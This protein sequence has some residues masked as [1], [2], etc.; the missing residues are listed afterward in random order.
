[1]E[2]TSTVLYVALI[3]AVG[4]ERVVELVISR[5]NAAWALERGGKEYGAAHFPF[6]AMLHTGFFIAAVVEVVALDRPFSL[7]LGGPMLVLAVG[8]Q[9]IRYWAIATLGRRWNVK[10]IVIPDAPAVD[11]GPYRFLKHPNY[12]AV[13][14]EGFA[15]PLIHGAWIT[16]LVF[17]V[18]N[19]WLLTVRIRCEERAL[20]EHNHYDSALAGRARIL[21]GL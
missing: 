13:I 3:A 5:R 16:A 8:A 10:V 7:L 9:A 6:M 1:M 11:R 21:P 17:S 12:L 15:L 14:V 18:A 20:T 4:L 19:A 2:L